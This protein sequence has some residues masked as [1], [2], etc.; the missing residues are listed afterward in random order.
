VVKN[1]GNSSVLRNKTNLSFRLEEKTCLP[2]ATGIRSQQLPFSVP[3]SRISTLQ[4]AS[5]MLEQIS[6]V[7]HKK[8]LEGVSGGIVNILGGGNMYYSE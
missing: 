8:Y 5:K 1:S 7:R 3:N 6:G 4:D 2:L